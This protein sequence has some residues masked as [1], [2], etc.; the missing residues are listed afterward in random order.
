MAD[1]VL[2]GLNIGAHQEAAEHFLSALSMQDVNGG[3]GSNNTS[4][5]LW[6]TLRRTFFA[7]VGSQSKN[8]LQFS[9]TDNF[10][11][12]TTLPIVPNLVSAW[13]HFVGTVSTFSG[14]KTET[15][16]CS[17]YPLL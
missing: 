15:L 5:Q 1:F 2:L 9:L 8:H 4:D 16:G 10:R 14:V 13:T 12:A 3:Q 7:M 11:N 17:N 6:S